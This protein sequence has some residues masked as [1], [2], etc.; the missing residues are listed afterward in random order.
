MENLMRS[1]LRM[2]APPKQQTEPPVSPI[3]QLLR[4]LLPPFLVTFL[5]FLFR[6]IFRFISFLLS[7]VNST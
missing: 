2:N 4:L 3:Q 1:S 5:N 6:I 7:F